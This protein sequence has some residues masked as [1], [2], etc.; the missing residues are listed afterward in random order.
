M[1][2]LEELEQEQVEHDSQLPSIISPTLSHTAISPANKVSGVKVFQKTI[3]QASS[4]TM[5][6]AFFAL[7]NSTANSQETKADS[8]SSVTQPGDAEFGTSPN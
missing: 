8:P 3:M 4:N 2:E 5:A 7:G 6:S 1:E